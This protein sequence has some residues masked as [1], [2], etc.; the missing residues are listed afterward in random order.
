MKIEKKLFVIV[1]GKTAMGSAVVEKVG[2]RASCAL[3]FPQP[4]YGK[5]MINDEFIFD[6]EGETKK[7]VSFSCFSVQSVR[8]YLFD[9][10]HAYGT[11]NN[12]NE[13]EVRRR[14]E[15]LEN[16]SK[17]EKQVEIEEKGVLF[18]TE[19]IQASD[20]GEEGK[21]A[22]R[23]ESEE[24]CD[25]AIAQE[26]YY[27]SNLTFVDDML[28]LSLRKS[29]QITKTEDTLGQKRD[30]FVHN[31]KENE[32]QKEV[33][34]TLETHRVKSVRSICEDDGE[35]YKGE[36]SR[37]QGYISGSVKKGRKADFYES[38]KFRIDE[39]FAKFE[40]DSEME[41]L[42]PDTKWVKINY[43]KDKFYLVGTVGTRPDFLCYAVPGSYSPIPP[44]CFEE[45][46]SFLPLDVR[47]PQGEGYW[48]IFQDG[49][50]GKVC[51]T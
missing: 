12:L 42:M 39:L 8:I 22:E 11:D 2:E 28:A 47:R 25:E 21:G 10:L 29:D 5:L 37:A 40:R 30:L 51:L 1:S 20:R 13:W 18:G 6:I 46:A 23:I 49:R 19:N 45:G 34:S 24:Y 3:T 48:L 7:K 16:K 41:R 15:E 17:R 27:P 43:D 33:A 38:V 35:G 26:N 36:E 44:A 4:F 50:T 32:A 31:I 14:L 9:G